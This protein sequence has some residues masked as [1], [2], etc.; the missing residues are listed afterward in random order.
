VL[1]GG[2]DAK[3]VVDGRLFQ[4]RLQGR[5][6]GGGGNEFADACAKSR[7]N[8]WKDNMSKKA[9]YNCR[10]CGKPLPLSVL[11]DGKKFLCSK[12]GQETNLLH[13]LS[14]GEL[15]RAG[16]QAKK[17]GLPRRTTEI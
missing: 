13:V 15:G 12:C 3:E 8:G 1:A 9:K 2:L 14:K 7:R 6:S 4:L 17:T 5:L 16:L 10:Q 11:M